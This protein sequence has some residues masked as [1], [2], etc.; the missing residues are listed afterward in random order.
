MELAP[1]QALRGLQ[2]S[3]GDRG[4]KHRG[5]TGSKN[6]VEN[7]FLSPFC[8][9]SGLSAWKHLPLWHPGGEPGSCPRA[10]A[11]SQRLWG[12]LL[13]SPRPCPFFLSC[14]LRPSESLCSLSGWGQ[15]PLLCHPS[16]LRACAQTHPPDAAGVIFMKYKP[17]PVFLLKASLW[18]F[19]KIYL[20][21]CLGS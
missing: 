14:A 10:L 4:V 17:G 19:F 18:F 16:T 2:H 6:E 9:A 11:L 20:F 8:V 12:P 13:K 7:N 5:G 21:G 3:S 15:W 1:S